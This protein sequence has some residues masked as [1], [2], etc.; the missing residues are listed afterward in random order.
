M[1]I[2]SPDQKNDIEE[3]V[4]DYLNGTISDDDW[5]RL[6]HLIASS[7]QA[8]EYYFTSVDIHAKLSRIYTS[9]AVDDLEISDFCM[10]AVEKVPAA[11]VRKLIASRLRAPILLTISAAAILFVV[12]AGGVYLLKGGNGD[13]NE[14]VV[15]NDKGTGQRAGW[16]KIVGQH[17]EGKLVYTGSDDRI[18]FYEG[19]TL[20]FPCHT[21][22]VYFD[23]GVEMLM[24]GPG[25][26]D[27]NRSSCFLHQGK[28]V[29]TVFPGAEGF[30][31]LTPKS[32]VTDYGTEFGVAVGQK[33]DSKIAVFEGE[34]GVDTGTGNGERM[35]R[36]GQGVSV[37]TQGKLERLVVIDEHTFEYQAQS[38]DSYA[39]IVT[40]VQDNVRSDELL[41]FYRVTC[42]GFSE[43]ARIYV[44]RVHE[45]NSLPN[46]KLPAYLD[47]SELI[48]TYNDDKIDE[49]FEM[50]ISLSRPADVY[51]LFD[52]RIIAPRWLTDNFTQMEEMVGI[53]EETI[54]DGP[55]R[56]GKGPG[57]SID[58]YF[59]IWKQHVDTETV[60]LGSNSASD[61]I[62][63]LMYSVI[64]KD[65]E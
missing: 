20:S 50:E 3:L 38:V 7:Q 41:D 46:S 30:Q 11:P 53:D 39:P 52:S 1:A 61:S 44:D 26:L 59:T 14:F 48:M 18:V 24:T 23:T 29:A 9:H 12:F 56:I 4:N 64:V 45:F 43:D 27:V 33:G 28:L 58:N 35:I 63:Q 57:N 15:S 6:G 19:Q 31:V 40:N 37:D 47:D 16:F 13:V 2:N 42:F 65:A 49:S 32:R 21:A 51:V 25:T 55:E 60:K 54:N 5:Q 36:T 62:F 17:C 8:C 22:Q 10:P 34:V